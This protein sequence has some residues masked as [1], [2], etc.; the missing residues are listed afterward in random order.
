MPRSDPTLNLKANLL[1]FDIEEDV[2]HDDDFNYRWTYLN[3]DCIYISAEND[4]EPALS[5]N[6]L[7]TIS[8]IEI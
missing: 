4:D 2:F 3:I 8:D 6:E 7:S 1:Y 5:Q